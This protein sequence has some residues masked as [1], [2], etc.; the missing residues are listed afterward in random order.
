VRR[1]A[2]RGRIAAAAAVVTGAVLTPLVLASTSS[3]ATGIHLI[4]HV[5]IITQENRS[6]DSYFGTYP[7][8]DGIPMSNGVPTVC[9]PDPVT[10][11]CVAPYVDHSDVNGGGPHGVTNSVADI[12]GGAMNGFQ[13][14]ARNAQQKCPRF[15]NPAC[16]A[17]ATPDVM[18]YHVQSD[19]PNY[20]SYA[21]HFVLQDHMY[22]SNDSW[23]LPSH[24]YEVSGWSARCTKP[25]QPLSCKGSVQSPTNPPVQNVK[26]PKPLYGWTD[27]TYLMHMD[28]VSWRYYVMNG[29]QP[30][31]DNDAAMGC[32]AV[33]QSVGTPSIWNPLPDFTTVKQDHQEGNIQSLGNF[34]Q[35]AKNGTLPSVSWIVPSGPVSEHPPSKVSAGQSYVTSLINAIGQSPDWSSTAIFLTW[36][37]WGGFYDNVV[38]PKVDA[39]GYGLRVPGILISPYA[40]A[41]T[42]DHQTLSFDA[43]NKFIEDDFLSSQRIDPTTDGRPDRRPDVRENASVLGDL[44]SDFDFSQ[45]PLPPLILPT[46]PATTLTG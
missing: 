6:F 41:G 28:N 32:A 31:C 30:D 16:S 3:A 46:N 27:L 38:P 14:A 39:N 12:N 4:Q 33:K 37:D 43:F 23:S 1:L 29:T 24:L 35:A 26:H 17:S 21:Q 15:T 42:I 20:W 40:K 18:G 22:E 7:G 2:R 44:S 5:I 36:D 25:S 45:T 11:A 9:S 13:A 8:A 34:Y 10:H 19:I